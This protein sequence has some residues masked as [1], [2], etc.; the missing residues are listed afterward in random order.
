MIMYTL[1]GVLFCWSSRV[2]GS[3][4]IDPETANDDVKRY[5]NLNLVKGSTYVMH[6]DD[7]EMTDLI[8]KCCVNR[9]G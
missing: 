3:H 7:K 8:D 9:R 5:F 2:D 1:N 6:T 4:Y